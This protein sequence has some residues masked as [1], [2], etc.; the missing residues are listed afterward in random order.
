MLA[1]SQV[2]QLTSFPTTPHSTMQPKTVLITGSTRGIG[3]EF[4]KHF[5][6][7]GWKVIG[8]AR[9]ANQADKLKALSPFKL[10]SFD[11]TDEAS[12]ARAAEELEDVPVDLL[13]NNAGIYKDGGLETTSKEMLMRQFEVNTTALHM[14][15]R[16]MAS[17]LKRD[18]IAMI[19]L[20]PGMVYTTMPLRRTHRLLWLKWRMS[21]RR[22]Q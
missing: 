2:A 13:I 4:A 11:C 18:N 16:N 12:I 19:I 22:Q 17:K 1:V 20:D 9:N 7:A 14:V 3:L 6:N 10:V 21:S 5:T 8:V 15:N